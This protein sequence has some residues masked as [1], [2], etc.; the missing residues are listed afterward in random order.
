MSDGVSLIQERLHNDLS[1]NDSLSHSK[2]RI[3]SLRNSSMFN[4]VINL[5]TTHNLV[6]EGLVLV[7]VSLSVIVM[8][9]LIGQ[10]FISFPFFL[11]LNISNWGV[12]VFI[13]LVS[14]LSDFV[15]FLFYLSYI[16]LL[17][18]TPIY[19]F[20]EPDCCFHDL[21]IDLSL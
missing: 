11:Y 10:D 6:K 7:D 18:H 21:S 12:D 20:I 5:T 1:I 3:K 16:G 15:I 4:I 14:I 9:E 19:L 2:Y 8:K 17:Y 13:I